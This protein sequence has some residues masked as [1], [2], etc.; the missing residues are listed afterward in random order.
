MKNT[1]FTKI[2]VLVLSLALLMGA[3][4][5]VSASAADEPEIFAQN[6]IYGDKISIVYAVDTTLEAAN[7]GDVKVKYYWE[8]DADTLYDAVLLDTTDSKNLCDGK[9]TFAT[10]GVAPKELGKVAYATVY[11]GDAPAADAE[12]KTYSVAEYLYDRLYKDGYVNYDEGDGVDY[13][14]KNAYEALLDLGANLQLVLNYNTNELATEYTYAYTTNADV[15]INGKRAAFDVASVNAVYSGDLAHVGWT[16]TDLEGNETEAD[17][18]AAIAVNGVIAISPKFDVHECADANNDHYCDKCS[19]KL[20][21][22]GE[23]AIVDGLCDVCGT[24]SFEFSVTTGVHLATG[25]AVLQEAFTLGT[26]YTPA[27]KSGAWGNIVSVTKKFEGG[28]E[29][30]SN[31]LKIVVNDG[32]TKNTSLTTLGGSVYFTPTK[33]SDDGGKFH[34][35]E[36]DFNWAQ[37]AKSGWRNPIT[38]YAWD[39]QGNKLGNVVDAEEGASDENQYDVWAVNNSG[40]FTAGTVKENAYQMGISGSQSELANGNFSLLNSDT[41]YR[42]RY[43]WNQETGKINIAASNDGGETWYKV[44][45]EQTRGSYADADYLTF[46]FTQFWG[47]GGIMYFDDIVYKVVSTM[48]DMPATNGIK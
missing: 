36:F 34:V 2:A 4:V 38:L 24:M 45:S 48:P 44:C 41:W 46:S 43:V 27:T 12:W 28:R 30:V 22:C 21:N 35:V 33:V 29:E 19:E 37:A 16:I 9:P 18:N 20:T 10:A 26:T 8:D 15:T 1:N 25:S 39:A 23:G 40:T 5:A 17:K 11:T 47:H 13:N 7:N 42:I 32:S 31:V 6:V 14:R 3:V